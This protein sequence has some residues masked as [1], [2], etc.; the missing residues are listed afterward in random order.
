MRPLLPSSELH[1][2]LVGP[3][4]FRGLGRVAYGWIAPSPVS[5]CSPVRTPGG[6]GPSPEI[7]PDAFRA[8]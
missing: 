7:H 3:P 5:H 8:P 2:S 6:F 4:G 1:C